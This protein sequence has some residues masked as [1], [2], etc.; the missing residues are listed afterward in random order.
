MPQTS[1]EQ[2]IPE[3]KA[4]DTTAILAGR[5]LGCRAM[6]K[7]ESS[8]TGNNKIR[9][10]LVTASS[11]RSRNRRKCPGAAMI[12]LQGIANGIVLVSIQGISGVT[13]AHCRFLL[14]RFYTGKNFVV[15]EQHSALDTELSSEGMLMS[16]YS[17]LLRRPEAIFRMQM[18]IPTL[19]FEI[20]DACL[21]IPRCCDSREQCVLIYCDRRT[22]EIV[23]QT[24]SIL[25]S[26]VP[27][28][29]YLIVGASR[30][31]GLAWL[32]FLSSS[33][34]NTVFGLVRDKTTAYQHLEA[35]G[36][37]GHIG[38][39]QADV[40]DLPALHQCAI[41]IS[42]ITGGSLDVLVNN[43]VSTG[44]QSAFTSMTQV[45]PGVLSQE[46]AETFETNVIGT[47]NLVTAFLPLIRKGQE[48]KFVGISSLLTDMDLT[49]DLGLDH[50]GPYTISKLAA[51]ALLNKYHAAVGWKESILFMSISPGIV[52][53][54]KTKP[55]ADEA[56]KREEISSKL[57]QFAPN[58]VKPLTPMESV[59]KQYSVIAAA[60]MQ[61]QGGRF[62]SH[63]GTSQWF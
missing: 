27:M 5:E 62:V 29:S 46:L 38:L 43:A 49:R 54:A 37:T 31:L 19:I 32:E 57:K 30:G 23:G 4:P 41:E 20:E 53:T 52:A 6:I 39:V 16:L 21:G 22:N 33:P 26:V 35:H 34:A 18:S 51:N 48:K 44:K 45:E 61:T 17:S 50:A 3:R 59:R 40:R 42:S 11:L 10:L 25:E 9:R 55:D 63:T 1:L 60:T 2:N 24:N 36:I 7:K 58:F 28:P 13:K 12:E 15:I 56:A 14:A 47:A 8:P